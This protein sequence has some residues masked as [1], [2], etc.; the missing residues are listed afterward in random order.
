MADVEEAVERVVA[1]LEKKN[2]L[3]NAEE[4]EIVAYHELGHALVAMAL[5]GTDPVRKYRSF[6]AASRP[7]VTPCRCRLKTAFSCAKPN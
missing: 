5:P 7:W 2:R 4:K 1:G 6:P 3:I